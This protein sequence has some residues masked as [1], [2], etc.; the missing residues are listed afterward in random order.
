MSADVGSTGSID[1]IRE[2]FNSENFPCVTGYMGK[3]SEVSWI[4]RVAYQLAED[5]ENAPP[6]SRAGR[7]RGHGTGC[8]SNDNRDKG[9]NYRNKRPRKSSSRT[10]RSRSIDSAML[11]DEYQFQT[12]AYHL[13]DLSVSLPAGR[14][15]DPYMLP[16]RKTADQLVEIYFETFHPSFPMVSKT[17]FMSQY[18]LLF[19]TYFPPF[20]SNRWLALLN[21]K[22]AIAA[23]YAK[24]MNF[25]WRGSGSDADHLR[26]FARARALCLDQSG[27]L[28]VADVQ[29]VQV[30]GLAAMYLLASNQTNRYSPPPI[31]SPSSSSAI[32]TTRQGMACNWPGHSIRPDAWTQPAQRYPRFG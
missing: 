16:D 19:E 24:L 21:L 31:F 11:E 8:N 30:M 9:S 2:D 14:P 17:L 29:H 32:I 1:H 7:G 22:F 25:Q 28:E 5:T 20:S 6:S 10:R 27:L 26:F 15:V 23:L 4:Q 13:D 18:G 12:P 3:S